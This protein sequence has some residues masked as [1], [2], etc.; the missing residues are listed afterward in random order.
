MKSGRPFDRLVAALMLAVALICLRGAFLAAGPGDLGG[1]E[2]M[3]RATPIPEDTVSFLRVAVYLVAALVLGFGA[4]RRWRG[5][6]RPTA[7]Q[8][9]VF[10]RDASPVQA[11]RPRRM[12]VLDV[13]VAV[14]VVGV[15]FDH[16]VPIGARVPAGDDERLPVEAPTETAAPPSATSTETSPAGQDAAAAAEQGAAGPEE[17]EQTVEEAAPGSAPSP[18]APA[19]DT[20]PPRTTAL[21]AQP[22][23]MPSH[24]DGHRD[25]V[26]WLSVSPDGGLLLSA[27]TDRAIKLWDMDTASL[28]R[29]LGTHK[30]MARQAL[31]MPDGVHA[32]T[33]GD[34]GEIVLRTLAEGAVVHV[35]AADALGAANK[36]AISPDGRVA[37]SGHRSGGVVVWDIEN[38]RV[39][40]VMT[41][42][43]WPVVSV[44]LSP[45][46]RRAVSGSID[47]VLKLWD[48][49]AG[50]Q[51]RDW[52]G[53]E[54]GAYGAAFTADGLRLV[55]GSGDFSIKLWDVEAGTEIRRFDGHSGTVYALVLSAD[56]RRILSGSLDGTAR[57]WD[58]DT[59][60]EIAQF[61]DGG[62]PVYA[63]AFAADGS[64][65]TGNRSGAIKAWPPDGKGA[66]TLFPPARE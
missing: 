13:L 52:L 8:A 65:L 57:I 18:G 66:K 32:L 27:S 14:I 29:E 15:V 63:V 48:I 23:P 12:H 56:E 10:G 17:R 5:A 35:F 42:H 38:R 36:I 49:D 4:W 21:P 54:R 28:R 64:V 51:A 30:E 60:R 46:G 25:A 6:S 16:F 9:P 33:A 26:V 37:V 3:V 31:F 39:R 34:D 55:T 61:A 41:G 62:G 58:V 20:L 2:T 59:G 40:H 44:A 43:A 50:H 1:G 19:A 47:G 53:H 11:G 7:T 24:A 22:A 45:D